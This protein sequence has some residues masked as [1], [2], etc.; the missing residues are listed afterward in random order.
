[1]KSNIFKSQ[2]YIEWKN[3]KE[4]PDTKKEYEL[5]NDMTTIQLQKYQQTFKQSIQKYKNQRSIRKRK[6]IEENPNKRKRDDIENKKNKKFKEKKINI[7]EIAL[8]NFKNLIPNIS[9]NIQNLFPLNRD[10]ERDRYLCVEQE[11]YTNFL[12]YNEICID[13]LTE[14]EDLEDKHDYNSTETEKTNNNYFHKYIWN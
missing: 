14:E 8:Q 13:E 5:I 7:S 10:A 2:E 9:Q 11:L 4:V 3:N 6:W 1:M 12:E